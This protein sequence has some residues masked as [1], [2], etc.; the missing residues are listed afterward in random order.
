MISCSKIAGGGRH[1][2]VCKLLEI[3]GYE[4]FWVDNEFLRESARSLW[5]SI[6]QSRPGDKHPNAQLRSQSLS[7][8]RKNSI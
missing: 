4:V 8:V 5:A 6:S 1:H 7:V 2:N 3:K